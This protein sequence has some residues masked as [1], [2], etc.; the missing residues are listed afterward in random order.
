MDVFDRAQAGE[1]VEKCRR[2]YK[3]GKLAS[4]H[5]RRFSKMR[6]TVRSFTAAAAFL[7]LAGAALA[8]APDWYHDR[9]ERFRGEHW[10]ARMF[11]EIRE[12]LNHVQS[13]TFGGRDEFRLVRTKQELNELQGDLTARR[14]NEAKLDEVIGSLQ[15]VVADNRMGPRDRDILNQDLE[16]LRDYRAHHEGWGH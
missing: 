4:A 5:R 13:V 11:T 8:Q 10:R 2:P 14:Y 12:D 15:R 1:S 6:K 7:I 16:H 3:G 9:E